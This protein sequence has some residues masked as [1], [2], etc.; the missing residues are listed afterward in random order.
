MTRI[1]S[2]LVLGALCIA[3]LTGPVF[4]FDGWIDP[5]VRVVTHLVGF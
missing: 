2:N 5:L 3:L 4:V 1:T